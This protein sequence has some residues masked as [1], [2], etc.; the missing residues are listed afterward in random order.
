M[1]AGDKWTPLAWPGALASEELAERISKCRVLA[2]GAG[3]IGCELLKT[4]VLTG[5]KDIEVA[6]M[7][8]IETSNLNRQ[9]LFRK[10]HVGQHKATVA[11]EAAR[12]FRPDADVSVQA[13]CVNII[14]EFTPATI[15]KFDLVMNG[16]DNL[17]ARIHMNRLC[18]AADVPLID[19]GTEGYKGQTS[20]HL[21]KTSQ[22][23]ECQPKPK[24]KSY[25]TCTIRNTPDQPIHCVVWA[26]DLLFQ[27]L[28]GRVE[29]ATDLDEQ[30]ADL[31]E[32][33]ADGGENGAADGAGEE[34]FFLR[35]TDE[36]PVAYAERIFARVY[37]HDIERV[38]RMDDLWKSGRRKPAPLDA[39]A[40][41]G[42][43]DA[44]W[45]S[46]AA[47]HGAGTPASL[48][49]GLRDQHAVWSPEECARVFV[50]SIRRI[51]TERAADVGNMVFDKEDKLACDFITAATNLRAYNYHIPTKP[52][53]ETKAMAGRIIHAIATTNAIVSG[54]MVTEALKILCGAR[55]KCCITALQLRSENLLAT[56]N[57]WPPNAECIACG[58]SEAS[59]ECDTATFT[60][61]DVLAHVARGPRVAMSREVNV[62]T[63]DGDGFLYEE[64]DGLD[65]EEQAEAAALASKALRDLPGA[66]GDADGL[67]LLLQD[68]KQDLELR[69]RVAHRSDIDAEEHPGG[70][71]L[72][73]A[74]AEAAVQ[75][76]AA[77]GD[78]GAGPSGAAAESEDE[79][80]VVVAGA[81]GGGVGRAGGR[82][83]GREDDGAGPSK[84]PRAPQHEDSDVVLLDD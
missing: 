7:D 78:A 19:S 82:K 81:E 69:V 28:F 3:G 47:A 75:A 54:L 12:A 66:K 33:P 73:S 26:K 65:G 21:K 43:A 57:L 16:L 36:D 67:V 55:H 25:P 52:L 15:G 41:L 27:R 23:F 38:L 13:H 49:C 32:Q 40:L 50:E 20:V 9:F 58:Q 59:L 1:A 77:N 51:L 68:N 83:R 61:G 42:G 53:F 31:D 64:G 76:K 35:Q 17:R 74:A 39:A 34:S 10:R 71:I 11:G 4:L 62:T 80:E 70:F 45:R 18:L 84:R 22:C 2:V 44:A 37:T 29:G 72:D 79:M 46:E 14:E 6:D 63:A 48:A 30:P 8:T 24:T 60:L 5:F 56:M